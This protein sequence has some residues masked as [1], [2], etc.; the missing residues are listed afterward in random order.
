MTLRKLAALAGVSYVTV[1]NALHGKPGVSQEVRMR[2]LALADEY[3]Y[4]VDR[5]VT[6]H[7]REKTRAIGCI[8]PG[9]FQDFAGRILRGVLRASHNSPYHVI[10]MESGFTLHG[11][12]VAIHALIEQ[13]VDGILFL[14]SHQEALP[15]TAVLGMRSNNVMPIAV[16][17]QEEK[18]IDLLRNDEQEMA[19]LAVDYLLRL[20]HRRIWYIGP[21]QHSRARAVTRAF[22]RRKLGG[23]T[24]FE[25][26]GLSYSL[27]R[28]LADDVM[29]H[30]IRSAP[31]P[32]AVIAFEDHI[33]V[34]LLQQAT[35]H[36]IRV[37]DDLSIL[38]YGNLEVASYVVPSITTIEQQP[39]E[40]GRRAFTLFLRRVNEDAALAPHPICEI[41]PAQL[42]Q[43]DSCVQAPT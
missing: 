31:A 16:D 29:S 4:H 17:I 28:R 7:I 35:R 22:N 43:R 40:L 30:L 34:Q 11:T 15:A 25:A 27:D 13:G 18:G 6:G 1:Y 36:G 23:S 26:T 38:G 32:T 39:E 14:C 33:A 21:T 19:D 5:S 37:P 42:L 10:P 9:I 8:V 24:L 3:Q 12:K 41:I 2:I 20:G